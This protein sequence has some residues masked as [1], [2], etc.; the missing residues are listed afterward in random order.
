MTTDEKLD[1]A[2]KALA[3]IQR[4]QA[5]HD[6][7]HQR[8]ERDVNDL[9]HDMYGNGSPGLKS[10][11]QTIED[12]CTLG[13]CHPTRDAIIHVLVNVI[14]GAI[15]LFIGWL[16]MVYSHIETIRFMGK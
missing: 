12:R 1:A 16:L 3:D 7:S 4:W 6:T 2:L 5:S 10:R 9:R 11:T 14:S 13:K 8:I 15:L